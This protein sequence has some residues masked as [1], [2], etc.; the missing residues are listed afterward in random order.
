MVDTLSNAKTN[1]SY[2]IQVYNPPSTL[3]YASI[4][5]QLV[6]SVKNNNFTTVLQK[7][8]A[9]TAATSPA[10]MT[11]TSTAVVV[12]NLSPTTSL[13]GSSNNTKHLSG[14]ALAGKLCY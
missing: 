2:I 7:N 1:V 8:A 12:T 4:Q 6:T 3:T 5:T 13:S 9:N 14:G 10:L 11:A